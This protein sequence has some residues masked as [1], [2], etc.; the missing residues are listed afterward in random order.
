MKQSFKRLLV[1][2]LLSL[3]LSF[4]LQAQAIMMN[5][6]VRITVVEQDTVYEWEYDNPNKYEYEEGETVIRGEKAKEEVEKIL[7]ALKLKEDSERDELLSR[8]KQHGFSKV[9]RMDIRL[10]N[11]KGELFTW[12]WEQ[13]E[14][15]T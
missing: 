12:I 11:E 7:S 4:P 2:G 13:N 10:M 8:L 5:N 1:I 15:G 3:T 6:S 9:T 14:E